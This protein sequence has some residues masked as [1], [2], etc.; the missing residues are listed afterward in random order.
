MLML[1]DILYLNFYVIDIENV[2]NCIL[3]E[4]YCIKCSMVF[5]KM[6]IMVVCL[7]VVFVLCYVLVEFEFVKCSRDCKKEEFE[8]FI[9]CCM[10]DVI[11]KLEVFGCLNECKI[12][13]EMCMV[14]CECFG[15]CER[16]FKVC[17]E[18]C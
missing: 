1:F 10:E 17:N 7:I 9:E 5:F 16:E 11:D 15:F 18:K 6:M 8:C 13:I 12:E 2:L 3:F 4:V 14:E